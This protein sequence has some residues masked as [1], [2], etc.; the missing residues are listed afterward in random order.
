MSPVRNS[1]DLEAEF[2]SP[3]EGPVAVGAEVVRPSLWAALEV[4][5]KVFLA[6]TPIAVPVVVSLALSGRLDLRREGPLI[7]VLLDNL[8]LLFAALL[9]FAPVVKV[10]FTRYTFDEEGIRV[11][12]QVLGRTDQRVPWEKV[13]ALR[14]RR[15]ILDRLLGLGRLDVIAYGEKGT[16]LRLVGLRDDRRLRDLVARRMRE[17]ASVASLFRND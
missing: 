2:L 9:A 11:R 3:P 15:G 16:V 13:T 14:H 7:V 12:V 10:A 17:S 6:L 1:R 4:L 5:A 8:E